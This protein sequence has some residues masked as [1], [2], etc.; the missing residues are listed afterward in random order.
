MTIQIARRLG[1]ALGFRR[2]SQI[3]ALDVAL[4]QY[5]RSVSA[6]PTLPVSGTI[7]AS[8]VVSGTFADARIAASNVEQFFTTTQ[9]TVGSAGA[10]SA[11]PATPTG[12]LIFDIAGTN[13]V[14]PFYDQS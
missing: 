8:Q 1:L 5:V 2:Q 11:L 14:I 13:R 9:L 4:R 12:Y 3:K 10:A 7:S 6:S